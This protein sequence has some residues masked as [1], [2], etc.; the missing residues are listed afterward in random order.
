MLLSPHA[1]SAVGK[2]DDPDSVAQESPLCE[3]DK[4]PNNST[5]SDFLGPGLL[6]GLRRRGARAL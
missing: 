4:V 1:V 2:A 6:R 5:H 3:R